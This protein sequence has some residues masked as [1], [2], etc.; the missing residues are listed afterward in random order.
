VPEQPTKG[1]AALY[2][3]ISL[4]LRQRLDA[5]VART[6]RKLKGE[7]S[8]AIEQYL[9]R[10]EALLAGAAT[11]TAPAVSPAGAPSAK[12]GRKSKGK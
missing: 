8:N 9:D 6:R 3:E 4:P 10:E 2:L 11:P 12:R 1:T 5:F 7:V